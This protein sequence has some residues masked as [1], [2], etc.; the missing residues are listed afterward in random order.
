MK[1]FRRAYIFV[2]LLLI[3]LIVYLGSKG[4]TEKTK[5]LYKEAYKLSDEVEE[6]IWEGYNFSKYPVAIRKGS[7]EYV[8]KDLEESRRK[9]VLPV[10]ANTAYRVEGEMNI[11]VV[12][13]E[14]MEIIGEMAEGLSG[15]GQNFLL[16][17]FAFEKKSITD[18]QY[19]AILFH[20]GFHAYQLENFEEQLMNMLP[21]VDDLEL[22]EW[23]NEV[24]KD[25]SLV[26]LYKKESML[27]YEITK[28][29]REDTLRT[30]VKDFLKLR[31]ERHKAVKNKFGQDKGEAIIGYE[32]FLELVEGTARYM[33]AE[34]A[35][36]LADEE[37][38]NQYI[39]SLKEISTGREKYYRSGMGIAMNLNRFD[40]NWRNKPFCRPLSLSELLCEVTGS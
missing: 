14:D 32:S 19:I 11:F 30:L 22:K 26:E 18:N 24:D 36:L 20:E 2:G 13:K 3:S 25:T 37:L 5:E 39:D 7:K 29:A 21:K 28:E 17:Q 33:E 12:S 38:Y 10:I 4:L 35:N 31:E 15:D 9:P 34:I 16:Q 1:W 27:L 40:K 8:I 6:K 23:M